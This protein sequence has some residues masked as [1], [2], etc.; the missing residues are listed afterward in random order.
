MDYTYV[1]DNMDRYERRSPF[2]YR[3]QWMGYIRNNLHKRREHHS[4]MCSIAFYLIGKD[5]IL[6]YLP[7][8]RIVKLRPPA[9]F[10]FPAESGYGQSGTSPWDELYFGY[11][12]TSPA[13]E[14]LKKFAGPL[15][16]PIQLPSCFDDLIHTLLE[17]FAQIHLPGTI[18]RMD[19]Q[20][21]N[22]ISEL[23]LPGE[24]EKGKK[25]PVLNSLLQDMRK[26]FRKPMDLN[27]FC[28]KHGISR[29][30][31]YRLWKRSMPIPAARYLAELRLQFAK[32]LLRTTRYTSQ[33]I[34][35]ESGFS[36]AA[37]FNRAYRRYY[38]CSPLSERKRE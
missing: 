9:V 37:T 31:F 11:P 38:G 29:A 19:L 10:V 17:Y 15:P 32:K 22:L 2:H 27:E 24:L 23:L 6:F 34:A 21:W 33:Q 28:L 30:S 5:E 36:D 14:A 16:K 8:K 4:R 3:L 20:A 13:A 25:D 1:L 26:N 12:G 35:F 7:E 18:D